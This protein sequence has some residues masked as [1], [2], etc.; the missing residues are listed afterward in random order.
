M[1]KSYDYIR[2]TSLDN[3]KD[4]INQGVDSFVGLYKIQ[5]NKNAVSST[6]GNIAINTKSL[7]NRD[8]K[9]VHT[10]E[11]KHS[12]FEKAN[13]IKAQLK[14]CM[15]PDEINK[16]PKVGTPLIKFLN[17]LGNKFLEVRN[18]KG[19]N[20]GSGYISSPYGF[21]VLSIF[22]NACIV[23]KQ[24]RD[25]I[26]AIERLEDAPYGLHTQLQ[27]KSS[28]FY[29]PTEL[30]KYYLTPDTRHKSVIDILYYIVGTA[31]RSL[32]NDEYRKN[33]LLKK[34]TL[35]SHVTAEDLE[36]PD[37]VAAILCGNGRFNDE[38]D[39][40]FSSEEK[41]KYTKLF[42]TI[43]NN[44][45]KFKS[46]K[47]D[48]KDIQVEDNT[49]DKIKEVFNYTKIFLSNTQALSEGLEAYNLKYELNT[50]NLSAGRATANMMGE[51]AYMFGTGTGR[52][53]LSNELTNLM[54]GTT[55]TGTLAAL[56]IAF[57]PSI[58]AVLAGNIINKLIAVSFQTKGYGVI[59][60]HGITGQTRSFL[61]KT[62][63]SYVTIF[64]KNQ[65]SFLF[66]QLENLNDLDNI[67]LF[68]QNEDVKT[69][70]SNYMK[71]K[72]RFEIQERFF[73]QL[74]TKDDSSIRDEDTVVRA[75][76][77]NGQRDIN[78][79]VTDPK[80]QAKDRMNETKI[81][82]NEA[83]S[84]LV[85]KAILSCLNIIIRA[86]SEIMKGY[87]DSIKVLPNKK[88]KGSLAFYLSMF[89]SQS[90]HYEGNENYNNVKIGDGNEEI[91]I[92]SKVDGFQKFGKNQQQ[93]DSWSRNKLKTI[94][95]N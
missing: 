83:K 3:I 46:L 17:E 88:E 7:F 38:A 22:H 75:N 39:I 34:D 55:P 20:S 44:H 58:I 33:L 21:I 4:A 62:Y 19:H 65:Y 49:S 18:R 86:E 69:A 35:N 59:H 54:G 41:E 9:F 78:Q 63:L 60:R 56:Q 95:K 16:E 14:L 61:L 74:N 92:N 6:L 2:F 73:R 31:L 28:L 57:P 47:K 82:M 77:F 43:K 87:T 40:F 90:G 76:S 64:I 30:I 66:K 68:S 70:N 80:G 85:D 51:Q 1:E 29:D 89:A 12:E 8:T 24:K 52:T 15:T 45:F 71:I 26:E 10:N 23:V 11:L 13:R 50:G 32:I 53:A 84:N 93:I 27:I 25:Q 72:E 94:V 37:K 67:V 5:D 81:Q 91:N 48:P 42:D 79:M 36:V